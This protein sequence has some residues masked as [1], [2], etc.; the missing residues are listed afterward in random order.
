MKKI[1]VRLGLRLGLSYALKPGTERWIGCLG[2]V[3]NQSWELVGSGQNVT[4]LVEACA[5]PPGVELVLG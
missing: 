2:P 3:S 4:Q 1:R 5:W